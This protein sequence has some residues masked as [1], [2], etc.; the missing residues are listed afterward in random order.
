MVKCTPLT[1][2]LQTITRDDPSLYAFVQD[3]AAFDIPTRKAVLTLCRCQKIGVRGTRVRSRLCKELDKTFSFQDDFGTDRTFSLFESI[4]PIQKYIES[5]ILCDFVSALV[6]TVPMDPIEVQIMLDETAR[7]EVTP[8]IEVRFPNTLL[9]QNLLDVSRDVRAT[10][11]IHPSLDS[12]LDVADYIF[13]GLQTAKK[14]LS[15]G[16]PLYPKY[17]T[18]TI[19][20]KSQHALK[21]L[22]EIWDM[23]YQPTTLG[24]EIMYS[25]TGIQIAGDTEMRSAFKYADIRP[26]CY[27]ARGPEAYY[28]SRFVQPIFNILVDSLETTHRR[29]RYH[30]HSVRLE[31]DA[32]LFIY[33]YSVFTTKLIELVDFLQQLSEFYKDTQVTIIDTFEGPTVHSVGELLSQYKDVCSKFPEFS[34]SDNLDPLDVEEDKPE[35]HH[36]TGMLGIPGNI[37][38]C[39]LL[40]GILLMLACGSRFVKTVGDDGM[41]RCGLDEYSQICSVLGLIGDFS[42]DKTVSWESKAASKMDT[43]DEDTWHYTKRPLTRVDNRISYEPKRIVWPPLPTLFPSMAD[44]LHTVLDTEYDQKKIAGS[45]ISFV[46][47]FSGIEL[48]EEEYRIAQHF[49]TFC[50]RQ[51]K[52]FHVDEKGFFCIDQSLVFPI[53]IDE[54]VNFGNWVD[55]LISYRSVVR[56]PRRILTEEEP[57]HVGIPFLSYMTSSIKLAV[58][59]GYAGSQK[60]Y[61]TILVADDPER[62]MSLMS[63]LE[64]SSYTCCISDLCPVWLFQLIKSDTIPTEST[65]PDTFFDVLYGEVA[66]II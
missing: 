60:E 51:S 30:V 4:L 27:Y 20:E 66:D 12:T 37:S 8:A 42:M 52:L 43:A 29:L 47:Q 9:W 11:P 10:M 7:K 56:F 36:R 55:R 50:L 2:A 35:L 23:D 21:D 38:A 54:G 34:L 3:I 41:G 17:S 19:P 53:S 32:I 22:W 25:R 1:R 6:R 65:D 63:G 40:H 46:R 61:D 62:F 44:S 57:I 26:R 14:R 15:S 64:R 31:D 33:D 13:S 59:L 18:K 16:P 28:S 45:M 58:D 39:T 48:Q 49:L 24:L 5:P